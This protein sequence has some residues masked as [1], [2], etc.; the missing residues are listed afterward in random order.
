MTVINEDG[1][2]KTRVFRKETHTDQYLSFQSNHP[3]EHKRG[4]VK[5]LMYRANNIVSDLGDRIKE[6]EHIR[7]ALKTNGYP[8]WFLD[9]VESHEKEEEEEAEKVGDLS[10]VAPEGEEPPTPGEAGDLSQVAPEG[11]EPPTPGEDPEKTVVDGDAGEG[12]TVPVK[13]KR[14]VVI[15]Y[16]K[17]VSEQLRRVYKQYDVPAFFKPANTLRQL[18]VRPKDKLD[19]EKV[20]G[21]VY[22]ISCNMCDASYIGE[23][24]RSLKARFQEHRRPSTVTSEVSRHIH[25]D[26]PEH[27]VSLKEA[28]VL[29]IEGRWFERGVKEAVYIRQHQPTLNRDGGRFNLPPVWTNL[30]RAQ[31]RRGGATNQ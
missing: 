20:V 5:T 26:H 16:I 9:R 31:A 1:S 13:K 25:A 10:Q 2:I 28:K 11:E 22:K 15:P 29:D 17:G 23:T 18:L 19:K 6:R 4:V 30:L 27:D 7:Q 12:E 14:A 8:E 3:L 24:E 21:P